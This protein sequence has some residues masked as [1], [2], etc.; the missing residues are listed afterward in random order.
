MK[1]AEALNLRSTLIKEIA[2]LRKRLVD[3][4]SIQ[5]DETPI[6][7][8]EELLKEL[9]PLIAQLHKLVYQIN[10]TNLQIKENGKSITELLA[11]RDELGMHTSIL[12]DALRRL[13][14]NKARY[15]S[16][17]IR[18]IRTVEPSVLRDL[19]SKESAKLRK[20][21]L[22]IQMLGW[23]HDLIEQ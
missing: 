3:C 10:L 2:E 21:N 15:R 13:N 18:Y 11:E 19:L 20:I 14:D 22:K 6:D 4:V 7:S 5:E 16:D 17:D 9:E 1:L 23:M 8:A 12:N